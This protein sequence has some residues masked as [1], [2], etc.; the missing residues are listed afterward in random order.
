LIKKYFKGYF[1][2]IVC[3][4]KIVA[5][6]STGFSLAWA[7]VLSGIIPNLSDLDNSFLKNFKFL[8]RY[9]ENIFY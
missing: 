7:I 2:S 6:A 9:I 3:N 1:L 8:W 4:K 5:L